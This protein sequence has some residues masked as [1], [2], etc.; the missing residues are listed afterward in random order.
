MSWMQK[1]HET[2]Q[3]YSSQHSLLP[4]SHTNQQAHIEITIDI[5]GNFK[6]ADI[7]HKEETVIPATEDSAVRS[8]TKPPPH[9]LCD[10]VRYCAKDYPVYGGKKPCFFAD[11]ETLLTQW[12]ASEFTHAKARAVLAY[13][14]KGQV[15]AD[16][17]R[18]KILWVGQDER[19]LSAWDKKQGNKPTSFR[20]FDG[21][22]GG[23]IIRWQV[24]EPGNQEPKVWADKSL[25]QA[26]I[27]FYAST[28]QLRNVCMTS[29]NMDATIAK[30]HPRGIRYSGDDARLITANDK[31]GY[32]FLGRFTDKTGQQACTIGYEVSQQA[33]SALYWL[34]R[35]QGYRNSDQ[36]VVSWAVSG[37]AI[38]D[39]FGSLSE[40]CDIEEEPEPSNEA[41]MGDR[42]GEAFGKRLSRKIAGY[43][44]E[45]GDT[46]DIVV[47]GLDSATPGRMAIIFYRELKSSEFLSRIENWHG[48]VA[49]HQDYGKGKKF[50]G[51][52]SPKDI[53]EA[54]YAHRNEKKELIINDKLLKST[55]ERLLPC[56]IDGRSLPRD[57]MDSVVRRACNRI[58]F[59]R[60]KSGRQWEWEKTLGIACALYRGFHRERD[61]QMTL[62]HERTSRDYLY[63]R[64]L[65]IAE[66]IEEMALYVGGES[67]DTQAA[68]LMQRFADRP[69]STWRTIELAL[70]PYKT[71]LQA[72]RPGF[73]YKK[74]A[75]LDDIISAFQGSD[76]IRDDK[77]SGEFLLGYHC[78]RQ[79]LKKSTDSEETVSK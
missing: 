35:Q 25:Q 54:A 7:V 28:K 60:D 44:A 19:L 37:H 70:T 53:A 34:I 50:V 15:V 63:G 5:H 23:A 57:L 43:R 76:F 48:S 4:V 64:L 66:H 11:Y 17:V 52:P 18:E 56:I 73:L 45:L 10:K 42:A 9:P 29:G 21:D 1:L 30:K 62:E 26:W 27:G 38:P 65:A 12:C 36:V 39:P 46:T 20:T 69:A 74:K 55:V 13:I 71:R 79:D 32:T 75:L 8:G 22:Q 58:A 68:R 72:K 59:E 49:W 16:L 33:H 78:Q 51:A 47:M 31:D 3:R 61:H 41:D 67:R 40:L 2:Y 77:L 14:R 24:W 6:R